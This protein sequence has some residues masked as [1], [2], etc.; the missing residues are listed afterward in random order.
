[1]DAHQ[2]AFEEYK[3]LRAEMEEHIAETL[4]LEVYAVAGV[5]GF[6]AW[7]LTHQKAPM[8]V[9]VWFVP[10]LLPL[11]GGLRCL[12]LHRQITVIGSYLKS[13]EPKIG[14]QLEGW[15]THLTLASTKRTYR[16]EL[17]MA[18]WGIMLLAT[19]FFAYQ[20]LPC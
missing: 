10:V 4:K 5:T 16:K 7:V 15:E 18:I 3:M 20:S 17:A 9:W 13:L 14:A 6:Y 19:V 2:F 11:L 8:P 1:M 12:A